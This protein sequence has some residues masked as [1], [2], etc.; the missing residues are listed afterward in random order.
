MPIFGGFHGSDHARPGWFLVLESL[1][2]ERECGVMISPTRL[3]E[4]RRAGM[5]YAVG[6]GGDA[7]TIYSVDM[8]AVAYALGAA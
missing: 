3:D 8:Q 2:P 1:H 6:E 5:V 7:V 4:M